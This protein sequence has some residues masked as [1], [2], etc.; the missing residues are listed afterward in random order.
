MLRAGKKIQFSKE[1]L[2][3]QN[4]VLLSPV[5]DLCGLILRADRPVPEFILNFLQSKGVK[6]SRMPYKNEQCIKISGYYELKKTD[7]EQFISE[8]STLVNEQ[9]EGLE[10][11]PIALD[12]QNE[13]TEKSFKAL[14]NAPIY[15]FYQ[16]EQYTFSG[17][18]MSDIGA[19]F[20]TKKRSF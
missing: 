12:L 2:K 9:Y 19:D 15:G 7:I 18:L 16:G 5:I 14:D 8:N 17:H 20:W 4:G 6:V 13:I 11:V 3:S 10:L 1:I